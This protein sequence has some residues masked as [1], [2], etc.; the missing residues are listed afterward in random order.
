MLIVMYNSFSRCCQYSINDVGHL[1]VSLPALGSFFFLCFVYFF[2]SPAPERFFVL[3][4]E[5]ET[6]VTVTTCPVEGVSPPPKADFPTLL[7]L[8]DGCPG[9]NGTALLAESNPGRA[10]PLPSSSTA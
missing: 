4:V 6:R 8:L 7:Y 5:E 2:S 10:K 1:F 9:N 3:E